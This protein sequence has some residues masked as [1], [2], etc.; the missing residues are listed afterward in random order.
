MVTLR[1][2]MGMLLTYN[3]IKSAVS[4]YADN[5]MNETNAVNKILYTISCTR[6]NDGVWYVTVNAQ[7]ADGSGVP[8]TNTQQ[9]SN[10]NL[11]SKINRIAKSVEGGFTVRVREGILDSS[12]DIASVGDEKTIHVDGDRAT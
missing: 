6:K 11:I 2:Y 3:D 7:R 4:L 1:A 10:L 12:D 8:F 9:I 5:E